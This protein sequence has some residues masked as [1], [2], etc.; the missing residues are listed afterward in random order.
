MTIEEK[1]PSNPN[2]LPGNE[3]ALGL[4]ASLMCASAGIHHQ[5]CL[6][7]NYGSE[8]TY[9]LNDR[10]SVGDT[11]PQ[12]KHWQGNP[13]DQLGDATILPHLKHSE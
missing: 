9:N 8:L 13:Y 6:L 7:S 2:N 1:I 3:H 12:P 11:D 5:K 4:I 10:E